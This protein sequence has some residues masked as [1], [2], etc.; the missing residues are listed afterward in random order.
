MHAPRIALRKGA[1][2]MG[3]KAFRRQRAACKGTEGKWYVG[4]PFPDLRPERSKGAREL[5]RIK[6]DRYAMT[7]RDRRG[8][9]RHC[10]QDRS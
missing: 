8:R 10:R 2:S 5:V 4:R 7:Y 3:R 9:V 6:R 1:L